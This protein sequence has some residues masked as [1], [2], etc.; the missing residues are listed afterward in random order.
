MSLSRVAPV[1]WLSIPRR[2]CCLSVDFVVLKLRGVLYDRITR[3][4]FCCGSSLHFAP[5]NSPSSEALV[6]SKDPKGIAIG[7]RR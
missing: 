5:L 6:I 2:S 7:W 4:F 3:Y 1:I